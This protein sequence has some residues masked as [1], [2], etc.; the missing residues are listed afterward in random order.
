MQ[1]EQLD[2]FIELLYSVEESATTLTS[3]QVQKL[4]L[5]QSKV[6]DLVA[7]VGQAAT[8]PVQQPVQQPVPVSEKRVH[9]FKTFSKKTY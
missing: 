1:T 3:D 8:I 6:S 4:Q 9:D 7:K 5:I 2:S